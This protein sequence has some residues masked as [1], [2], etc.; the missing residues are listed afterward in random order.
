M[1]LLRAVP[2]LLFGLMFAG[3]GVFFL[4]ETALPV[5]QDWRAMQQ[6]QPAQAQLISV[7]GGE[8]YTRVHY[9]YQFNGSVFEGARA[10]LATF[11]DNIGS[12]HEDFYGWLK[13]RQRA[14]EPVPIWVDPKNP[15]QAVI[16]RDMRWGL[17]ALMS[18]FCSTFILIGLLVMY[19][20]LSASDKA[21]KTRRPSLTELRKEW[22]GKKRQV[23]GFNLGFM[24]YS[25]QRN[26]ELEQQ[27]KS[28]ASSS[29]WQLKKG[30]ETSTIRSGAKSGAIAMWGFAALWSAL[31][32]PLLWVVPEEFAKGNN[33]ALVGLLFPLVG[34]LLIGKAV[35]MTMEYRRF[36]RVVFEM[37]P[38]PGAIGGHV[39][40]RISVPR[41]A[42]ATATAP[43][44]ELKVRLEC[45]YSYISG[46]GKNRSRRESVKWAEEGRPQVENTG[47]GVSL[48]FRFDVPEE[49]PEA[50]VERAKAY[51]LW[52][53]S[54]D[55]EIEGIDL[56]RRYNIP[57]FRTGKSSSSVRHDISAQ[58]L[59]ERIRS[60]RRQRTPLRKGNFALPGLSRAMRFSDEGGEIRMVFPMFRNKVLTVFAGVFAGGFGF[61]SYKMIGMAFKGGAFGLFTGLF[62]VPFRAGCTG[63]F[64]GDDIPAIE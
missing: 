57:A 7:K 39:G 17:F 18:G 14:G 48:A 37:D 23:Q 44:A 34:L 29:D 63:C 27:A 41:L 53:L 1:R 40:G 59:K 25:Q 9:E 21:E 36:G 16:D 49:L 43:S 64:D 31:S 38:Y 2:A 26:A 47:Q 20:G 51:H 62:S 60:L 61:A 10:Y 56:R 55:A 3:G 42:Y 58:V 13:S 12:Y 52:R 11:N 19:A 8:R 24:E 5:W 46:S 35:S 15:A 6:W 32:S 45:I 28:N 22:D 33:A 50:D 54:V 4:S 30:W